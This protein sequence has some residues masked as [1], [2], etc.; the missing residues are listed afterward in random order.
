MRIA[1][2]FAMDKPAGS[3]KDGSKLT[4]GF[5]KVKSLISSKSGSKTSTL[6][7]T[8]TINRTEVVGGL[9]I[10]SAGTNTVLDSFSPTANASTGFEENSASAIGPLVTHTLNPIEL[11]RDTAAII[12]DSGLDVPEPHPPV[13][14]SASEIIEVTAVGNAPRAD[15]QQSTTSGVS[16]ALNALPLGETSLAVNTITSDAAGPSSGM[17][18]GS[19]EPLPN[20]ISKLSVLQIA[21]AKIANGPVTAFGVNS[22]STDGRTAQPRLWLRA[23]NAPI[24]NQALRTLEEMYKQ[25]V[26]TQNSLR[27]SHERKL[28]E[29]FRLDTA[30]PQEKAVAQRLKQYLPSLVAVRGIAMTAAALDP[31]KIAPIVCACV[32]FS[33]DVRA[34]SVYQHLAN[35]FSLH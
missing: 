17:V 8:T 27:E 23:K 28:D 1:P 9:T 30:K 20:A 12:S 19:D 10:R 5:E 14:R 2:F 21:R 11:P 4:R 34:L 13:G 35:K 31:H 29:L 22:T 25:L 33:I 26:D 18:P 16:A 15:D 32:F 6:S 3:G 24:W 7:S